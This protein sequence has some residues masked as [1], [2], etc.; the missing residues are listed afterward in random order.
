MSYPKCTKKEDCRMDTTIRGEVKE[1]E[2]LTKRCDELM[3]KYN[4]NSRAG[5]FKKLITEDGVL[6]KRLQEN[7]V[8]NEKS[9]LC[10]KME[11]GKESFAR[12]I[13]EYRNEVRELE[14]QQRKETL[15]FKSKPVKKKIQ[16]HFYKAI[17][18]FVA[19]MDFNVSSDYKTIIEIFG[20]YKDFLVTD[21]LDILIKAMSNPKTTYELIRLKMFC[22]NIVKLIE[23]METLNDEFSKMPPEVRRKLN[24]H[25]FESIT[26]ADPNDLA[27]WEKK[28][29]AWKKAQM[30]DGT[31]TKIFSDE[32]DNDGMEILS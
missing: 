32:E 27:I 26:Y 30:R 29:T 31:I 24:F 7:R 15:I 17:L 18:N 1:I 20:Q 22:G 19:T 9:V 11:Q 6:E 4:E 25:K 28:V 8:R 21:G 23:R 14:E 5:L 12:N 3:K 16:F 10:L 13:M 2:E